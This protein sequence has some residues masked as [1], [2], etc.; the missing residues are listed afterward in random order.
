VRPASN[1]A[2]ARIFLISGAVLLVVGLVMVAGLSPWLGGPV[3]LVGW[4]ALV[5]GIHR[6]GRLGPHEAA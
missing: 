6:F 3:V 4:L 1:E 5:L 2:R